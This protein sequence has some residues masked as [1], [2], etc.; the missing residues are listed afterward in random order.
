MYFYEYY[1]IFICSHLLKP[2]IHPMQ[3]MSTHEHYGQLQNIPGYI[4]KV[5]TKQMGALEDAIQRLKESTYVFFYFPVFFPIA[6]LKIQSFSSMTVFASF[7]IMLTV[8][9]LNE[10]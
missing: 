5:Q 4:S 8:F 7:I 6:S 1:S 2:C 3:A 9:I 10:Y